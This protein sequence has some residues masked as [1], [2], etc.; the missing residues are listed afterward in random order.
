MK[1]KKLNN[2]LRI[3][4]HWCRIDMEEIDKQG[5]GHRTESHRWRR[6]LEMKEEIVDIH[7]EWEN[8]R[9]ESRNRADDTLCAYC[10][11]IT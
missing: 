7:P 1:R 5:I 2:K 10:F 3:E 11:E 9:E 6:E 4:I 8:V